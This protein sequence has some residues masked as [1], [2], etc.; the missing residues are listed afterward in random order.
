MSKI[1]GVV[2]SDPLGLYYSAPIEHGISQ[3]EATRAE[4]ADPC[5][6]FAKVFGVE[7]AVG[8]AIVASGAPVIPY[9]RTGVGSGTSTGATSVA[10]STLSKTFPQRLPVRV[11]TPTVANPGAK[12]RVLGRAL[13][14]WVPYAGWG[15]WAIDAQQL[16]SCLAECEECQVAK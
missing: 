12:T 16:A 15:I 5:G 11:P 4:P 13:G 10:S 8:G 2:H 3:R 1:S 7:T 14:R 6:C 9:P